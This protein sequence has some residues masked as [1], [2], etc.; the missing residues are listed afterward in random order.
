MGFLQGLI[1][2]DG[3]KYLKTKYEGELAVKEEFPDATIFRPADIFGQEDRFMRYYAHFWRRTFQWMPLWH[4]GEKTIKQ[5][6]YVSDVAQGV[7]NALRDPESVGKTYDIVGYVLR[8]QVR[9]A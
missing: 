2:P 1:L 8:I 6:V 3:S 7:I 5:P 4:R 9:I